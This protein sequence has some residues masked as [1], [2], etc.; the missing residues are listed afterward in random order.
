MGTA[1]VFLF[2]IIL[3]VLFVA[4]GALADMRI[5]IIVVVILGIQLVFSHMYF[6]IIL[7]R[8]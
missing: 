2:I 3:D 7:S 6:K 1:L 8:I 4:L 5:I